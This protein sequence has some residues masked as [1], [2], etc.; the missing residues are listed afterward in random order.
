[1]YHSDDQQRPDTVVISVTASNRRSMETYRKAIPSRK[2]MNKSA[3]VHLASQALRLPTAEV[4][5]CCISTS[6]KRA[7]RR[8]LGIDCSSLNEPYLQDTT[9]ITAP[10]STS[11]MLKAPSSMSIVEFP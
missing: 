5:I 8:L 10:F 7:H 11:P 2:P 1:M 3:A 4:L 6:L 9:L